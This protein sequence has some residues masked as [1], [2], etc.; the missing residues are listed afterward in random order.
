M[1]AQTN[2]GFDGSIKA[3]HQNRRPPLQFKMQQKL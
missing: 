2:K 1:I 3:L